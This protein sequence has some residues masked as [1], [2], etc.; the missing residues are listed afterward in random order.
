MDNPYDKWDK[1]A[2]E[3]KT[4]QGFT[5]AL[6]EAQ[7]RVEVAGAGEEGLGEDGQGDK[8]W[9]IKREEC[10]EDLLY[11]EVARDYQ[12]AFNLKFIETS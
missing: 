1:G 9:V 3:R 4:L 12:E 6:A 5:M 2:G 10:F 11:N 7:T 8:G